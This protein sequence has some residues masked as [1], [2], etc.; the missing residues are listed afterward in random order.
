MRL[1]LDCFSCFTR[2][3]LEMARI[4]TSDTRVHERVLREALHAASEWDRNRPAPAFSQHLQRRLRALTGVDDPYREAK[5]RFNAMAL[6]LL[7]ALRAE[8]ERAADPLEA[9]V[10]VAIAGNVIDMGVDGNLRA[11]DVRAS[12]ARCAAT[13]VAGDLAAFRAAVANARRIL[14][15]TDNTGEIVFDRLLVERLTAC[16]LTIAVRGA[17]TLNDATREDARLAG[18][19][20]VAELID[21]G[22]DAPGTLLAECSAEFRERFDSA[23]V[24]VA[25]GQGNFETLAGGPGNIFFLLKIKCPVVAAHTGLETG[26]HAVL[27]YRDGEVLG[28]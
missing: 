22:S 17:A 24:I 16:H 20:Q 1:A 5:R 21:N 6:E 2:H 10:R 14:Y 12:L 28:T 4:T 15:L 18:L 23:D 13:P 11:E 27:S 3:T 8:V 7:P 19:D 26:T 25:K 9:A